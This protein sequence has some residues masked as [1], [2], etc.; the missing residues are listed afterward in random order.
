M[1]IFTRMY[2]AIVGYMTGKGRIERICSSEPSNIMTKRYENS[3]TSFV[4]VRNTLDGDRTHTQAPALPPGERC[5]VVQQGTCRSF[6]SSS[7]R[8][9]TPA[10]I[11]LDLLAKPTIYDQ[12]RALVLRPAPF[13]VALVLDRLAAMHRIGPDNLTYV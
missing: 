11:L 9:R 12:P 4:N 5:L 3:I 10:G 8:V 1:R 7:R 13:D 2:V 6:R